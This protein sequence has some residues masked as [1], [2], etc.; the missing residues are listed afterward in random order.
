MPSSPRLLP[1]IV[2]AFAP[3][4]AFAGGFDAPGDILITDQ[5]N[6]RVIEID[7]GGSIV[8]QFGSGDPNDCTPGAGSV[9]APNDAERLAGGQT[10]IAGTGTGACP[11][12]RV[13]V[14][15][16]Q[17]RIRFQYGEAGIAGSG[18]NQL[19]TPVFAVQDAFGNYLIT[20]QGN[21]RIILVDPRR[22][23]L[24]SYGPPSGEGALNS[25]N[26]AEIL[27]NGHILIADENNNRVLEITRAGQIVSSFGAGLNTVAFASRLP[28][29]DTL[30]ADAGNNRVLEVDV[31][32]RTVSMYATN[33]GPGSNP[34]PN[35]TGAIRLRNGDTLIADQ[36]NDRVIEVT[37]GG[38]IAFQYGQTNVV[39]NGT[40]Q[41]NAPYSAVMIG[42]YLG[43][44]K[45]A[46]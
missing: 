25:P 41:L 32:G 30:I 29:G 17:G 33:T 35:P 18:P 15:D 38:V 14:V 10:L 6:N 7:H 19:N 20:D 43:V 46:H 16:R 39:G 40:N 44:T 34:N 27:A 31:D 42:Q 28:D 9:I 45:P 13:I 36:F 24:W 23:I 2:L 37:P 11:D 8:W 21:N 22:N 1:A 26:S 5:F 12:N 4:A 3:T